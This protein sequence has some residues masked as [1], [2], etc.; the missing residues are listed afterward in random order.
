MGNSIWY[1]DDC[2]FPN[3]TEKT[4]CRKCGIEKPVINRISILT[5]LG[6]KNFPLISRNRT[7][8]SLAVEKSAIVRTNINEYARA[9]TP[10]LDKK[11]KEFYDTEFPP[12]NISLYIDG[13]KIKRKNLLH[14]NG[15]KHVRKWLRPLDIKV[16]SEEK[17]LPIS[18]F[19]DPSPKDVIQGELGSCWFLSALALLVEKPFLLLNCMVSQYYNP[20]G[21][22]QVR[23]CRRG[24]WVVVNV[25]DYLPCDKSDQ[26][27]FSL[28]RRRQLWVP[29]MEKALAKLYGSYEAIARGA[30]ADG[31]Q[32][33]T[34]EPS[35][36]LYLQLGIG[37]YNYIVFCKLV[38]IYAYFF[39]C[40]QVNHT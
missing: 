23:L 10:I 2:N 20:K 25:D 31:L 35:E 16:G 39:L 14:S 26:L 7:Q 5:G 15:F 8:K 17:H 24:E 32:S 12:N 22:Y 21:L 29:L 1:C 27:V 3:I 4:S 28:G 40:E 18:L 11:I 9:N 30:C 19:S 13:I 33:L 38:S 36:V 34:G 6:S 37:K